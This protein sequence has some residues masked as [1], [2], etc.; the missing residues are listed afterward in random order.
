[1]AGADRGRGPSDRGSG[2]ADPGS[3]P[4]DSGG[5]PVDPGSGPADPGS[6]PVDPGG[7]PGVLPAVWSEAYEVEIGP[8][9]F[10]TSK[11]RLVVE[12]LL[13]VGILAPDRIRRPGPATDEELGRV[14]HE[15]YLRRIR[16]GEL[17][18]S[19]QWRLEVPFT[20]ELLRA[21]VL[22]AGGSIL[23]AR[24]ALREGVALHV[25]GGFH[26][27]FPDHGEGF[28]LLN[29]V[30]VAVAAVLAE[31]RAGRVSV[32]DCDVH[33][34]NGTA[35]VFAGE[36]RVFTLSLHQEDIYPAVKPPGDLDVGLEAGTDDKTYLTALASALP[37]ALER[38]RPD[39]VLYLA[40]ADPYREDQ[41]GGLALTRQGLRRRDERVLG[42]A[43]EAGAAVAVLLAGG[44][45]LRLED[46]VAIHCGTARAAAVA[47]GRR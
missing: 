36:E 19:E 30:A 13:E 7:G 37:E 35:A 6:G 46:T 26:H 8:H 14:H 21:S 32:V 1:V 24:L 9:V 17:S 47:L 27:A 15:D 28:C 11:Y 42:A 38:H 43:A 34:G 40:G 29:D 5:G 4:A 12:R 31:G 25:G 20:D 16:D 22:C 18:L 3:G 10:P 41:L 44:Y 23:A 2:P 39:L 45:A 33:H